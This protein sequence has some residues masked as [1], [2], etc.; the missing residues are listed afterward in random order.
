MLLGK[1]V[2]FIINL[3]D[4][5]ISKSEKESPE[6]DSSTLKSYGTSPS[7]I[8]ASSASLSGNGNNGMNF[9]VYGATGGKIVEFSSYDPRTDRH[10]RNLYIVTDKEDLGEEL[11]LIITKETLTR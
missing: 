6:I 7:A 1:L 4:K 2:K 3:I 11:A 10:T 8:P 5:S 9:V